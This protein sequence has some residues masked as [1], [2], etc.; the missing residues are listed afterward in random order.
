MPYDIS[1]EATR[2]KTSMPLTQLAQDVVQ[3]EFVMR[4][5]FPIVPVPTYGGIIPRVDDSIWEEVD[6]NRADDTPYPEIQEGID[7]SAFRLNTKGLSYRVPDKRRREYANLRINWGRRAVRALMKRGGLMH[8]IEAA[9]RAT[10][11]ANYA[12]TNRIALASGSRF[13]NVDP[14]PIIRTGL[15]AI[16]F[17]SGVN[18]NI[19]VMGRLVF[20][21]LAT[22][23]AQNF[24]STGT[25]PGLR[26][27]L[28]LDILAGIYGVQ[29]MLICNAIVKRNGVVQ[30]VFGNHMVL[31]YVPPEAIETGAL[32]YRPN[33]DMDFEMDGSYGYTLAIDG[34]PR[35]SEP[36]YDNDR[37]ATVYKFDFDRQVVATGVNE[38][39]AITYGYLIENAV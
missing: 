8:E 26:N 17:N 9:L 36:Y 25:S 22:K 38:A 15:S 21:A 30:R 34:D 14:D 33:A 29:K 13:Q 1:L 19:G 2:A 24:T 18:A 11:P 7:G 37:S 5:L 32:N 23:F 35:V 10:T 20:D 39:G 4:H 27:Q 12:T 3:P 28:T 16:A 31:G 6:D